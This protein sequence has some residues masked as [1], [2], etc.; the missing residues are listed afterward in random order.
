MGGRLAAS[1]CC[2]EQPQGRAGSPAHGRGLQGGSSKEHS[3]SSRASP[4]Q[5]HVALTRGA[6]LPRCP[7]GEQ[8]GLAH[9]APWLLCRRGGQALHMA[10]TH[11]EGLE[12]G[13]TPNS[14]Q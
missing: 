3:S 9:A 4:D 12:G 2:Q 14:V 6:G 5:A 11:A 13:A 1:I 7:Q 10:W 8:C